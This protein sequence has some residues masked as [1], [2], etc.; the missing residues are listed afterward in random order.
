MIHTIVW[1]VKEIS[2]YKF[3]YLLH[4]KKILDQLDQCKQFLSYSFSFNYECLGTSKG[5]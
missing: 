4:Y 3:R 5:Y 2:K 1:I